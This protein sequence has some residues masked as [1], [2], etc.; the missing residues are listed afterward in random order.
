MR[1]VAGRVAA[2]AG[3]VFALSVHAAGSRDTYNAA[4]DRAEVEYQS[5]IDRCKSLAGNPRDVCTAEAKAARTRTVATAEAD[6]KQTPKARA[7]AL[8]A[9]A[10]ADHDVAKRRCDAKTGNEK[11]VCVKEAKAA[12]VGANADAKAAQ[13]T[14]MARADAADDKR[15][16]DY[17][18]AME[19]CDAFAGAAKDN[20]RKSAKT[21]YGK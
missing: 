10:D 19:K 12:L 5:A 8:T 20:C 4:K 18:V 7:D 2:L 1:I 3:L 21:T 6:Y 13:K 14:S 15:E 16:A 9:T 17:Q 11:D